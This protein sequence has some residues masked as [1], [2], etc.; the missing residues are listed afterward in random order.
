MCSEHFYV[1]I[2]NQSEMCVCETKYVYQAPSPPSMGNTE[3][4]LNK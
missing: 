4:V 3:P 2:Q 1:I